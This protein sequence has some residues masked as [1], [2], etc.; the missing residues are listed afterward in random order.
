MD[1]AVEAHLEDPL[2]SIRPYAAIASALHHRCRHGRRPES[3]QYPASNR[4]V[5]GSV[6]IASQNARE[7]RS[8]LRRVKGRGQIDDCALRIDFHRHE[9]T[10]GG[11]LVDGTSRDY[12]LLSPPWAP[13]EA[14][15]LCYRNRTKR[16]RLEDTV[17]PW[18]FQSCWWLMQPNGEAG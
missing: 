4:K 15:T 16:L 13:M 11:R 6:G 18:N 1:E 7:G 14:K 8:V 9:V 3:V 10:I 12:R 5:R 17:M 2:G